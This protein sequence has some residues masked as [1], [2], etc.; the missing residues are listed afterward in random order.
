VGVLA[1]MPVR[2]LNKL[3]LFAYQE[4]RPDEDNVHEGSYAPD[5]RDDA[6]NARNA[7]LKAL[8][9]SEG[10]A[11][12]KAVMRLAE[13]RDMKTRRIRVRELARRMAERDADVGAWRP[14]NVLAFE[15]DKLCR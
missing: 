10:A 12:F 7:I 6:E 15:R 5:G 3:V 14:E 8:I 1:G 4:V 11:A 13:H 9:D 2:S